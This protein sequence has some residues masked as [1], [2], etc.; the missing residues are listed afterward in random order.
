MRAF[1]ERFG[2]EGKTHPGSGQP[3][4]MGGGHGL[5]RKGVEGRRELWEQQHFSLYISTVGSM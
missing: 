1:L 3:L 2:K 5:S 4:P